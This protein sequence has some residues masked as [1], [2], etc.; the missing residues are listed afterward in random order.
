MT[1]KEKA[2]ELVQKYLNIEFCL[3]TDNQAKQ[4]ALICVDEKQKSY[5]K[6]FTTQEKFLRLA[7]KNEYYLQLEEVKQ[8]INKLWK[9]CS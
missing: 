9:H 3:L 4:C 1:A 2:K 8:E 5:L 7:H 6:A